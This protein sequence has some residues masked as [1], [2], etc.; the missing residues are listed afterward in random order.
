MLNEDMKRDKGQE[1]RRQVPKPKNDITASPHHFLLPTACTAFPFAL[2]SN[3]TRQFC[4]FPG[5]LQ[6]RSVAP[7]RHRKGLL[8]IV[9]PC[10]MKRAREPID[11]YASLPYHSQYVPCALRSQT[12]DH[13]A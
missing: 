4:Y 9:M 5:S 8:R 11:H 12:L 10:G 3:L 1:Q 7:V 2:V 13:L 6:L